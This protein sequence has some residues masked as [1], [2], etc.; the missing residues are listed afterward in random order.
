MTKDAFVVV[1]KETKSEWKA[2]RDGDGF[3][4]TVAGDWLPGSTGRLADKEFW[5]MFEKKELLQA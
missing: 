2:W 4:F 5:L 1:R 3:K